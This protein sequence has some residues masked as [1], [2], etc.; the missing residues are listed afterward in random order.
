WPFAAG[1]PDAHGSLKRSLEPCAAI[2]R[3]QSSTSLALH[4]RFSLRNVAG[5]EKGFRMCCASAV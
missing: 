1:R 4:S 2:L 3:G 5:Y